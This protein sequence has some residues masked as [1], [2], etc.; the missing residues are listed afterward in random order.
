MEEALRIGLALARQR[1]E[2]MRT[3][4][5]VLA[6][7]I[8]A[9]S[10][11]TRA[12]AQDSDWER[13]FTGWDRAWSVQETSDGGYIIGGCTSFGVGRYDLWLI[14]TDGL[15][16]KQWDKTFGGPQSDKVWS[17]NCLQQTSDGG[18]VIVGYTESFGNGGGTYDIWLI[19][20]DALGNKQWDRTFG[21][22]GNE[23]GF[24]VR[25][26]SDGGYVVVG[27]TANGE[28]WLI[29]T[30]NLGNKQWDR[31]FGG[32]LTDEGHCVQQ[33]NDGGYIITGYTWSYGAGDYDVWLIKTDALGN[34]QWDKTFGGPLS[35]EGWSVQQTTDGGYIVAGTTYSFGVGW[36][37]AWLIKTDSNGNEQW[38]KIFGGTGYDGANSV[39]LTAD[40]G[41]AIAG[42][43]YQ[44]SFTSLAWLVKTDEN[45][46]EQ[47]DKTFSWNDARSV[48]QTSDGNYIITGGSFDVVLVKTSPIETASLDL[49]PDAQFLQPGSR[50]GYTVTLRNLT[51]IQQTVQYWTD[52]TLPEGGTYPPSRQL[53]GP[54][55][56]KLNPR[57]SRS[58]HLTHPVPQN[59]AEGGYT[60]NAYV[61]GYPA[62]IFDEKHFPFVISPY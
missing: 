13:I 45:G 37:A 34:K 55:K 46:E 56:V 28:V 6:V 20:T 23:L 5:A 44:N 41:Y 22:P 10:F 12:I 7:A 17:S 58:A 30:D 18:Y 35:D 62:T 9:V 47:W 2:I 57:A 31:T 49:T 16:N 8:L 11:S 26:T 40:G 1:E 61:G 59:A 36:R 25:Q 33:T 48:Q 53:I 27:V 43:T 4:I 42:T 21:G 3:I 29:K 54:V 24:G 50:L 32:P 19:K 51:D 60:Y 39:A 52:V 38:D 14:K 15:G